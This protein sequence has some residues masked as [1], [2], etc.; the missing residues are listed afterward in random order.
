MVLLYAHNVIL[1]NVFLCNIIPHNVSVILHNTVTG[2]PLPNHFRR[3]EGKQAKTGLVPKIESYTGNIRCESNLYCSSHP[4]VPSPPAQRYTT[5][6]LF[7]L[8]LL[9]LQ[10]VDDK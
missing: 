2:P 5:H 8:L 6:L 1:H 10:L 3:L 7:E 4:N 9:L